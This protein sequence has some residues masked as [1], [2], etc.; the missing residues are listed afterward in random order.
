MGLGKYMLDSLPSLLVSGD[1]SIARDGSV[2][3]NYFNN[4]QSITLRIVEIYTLCWAN[5]SQADNTE[6]Q[7]S[8][9][10]ID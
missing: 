6:L 10:T 9:L 1:Q 7:P 5:F 3:P 8:S 2:H 4:L